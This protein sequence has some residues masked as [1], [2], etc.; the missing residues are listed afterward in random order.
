MLPP[1]GV[2]APEYAVIRLPAVADLTF[3]LLLDTGER[4][5]TDF[6]DSRGLVLDAEKHG[7]LALDILLLYSS[8]LCP[9]LF[10]EFEPGHRGAVDLV[11]AVGKAQGAGARPEVGEREVVRDPGAPVRLYGPVEDVEG[12]VWG[13]DLDHGDLGP[14]LFVP[15]RI[16]HVGRLQGQE[17]RLLYLHPGVR[18]PGLYHTLLRERFPERLPLFDPLAHQLECPFCDADQPHAV[19]DASWPEASLGDG[20]ALA[21]VP[22]DV[23]LRY[24]H[25]VEGDLR[26]PVRGVVV[27]EDGEGPL[28]L[29][30]RRIER[31]QD[32]GLLLVARRVRVRLAHEDG[33][34]AP[35][36][37]CPRD[38]PLLAV[39]DV[40]V[41]VLLYTRHDVSR[42]RGS[43]IRLGHREAG[44]YLTVEQRPQPPLF[45]L[46]C[47][48]A[49]EH[50]HVARVWGVTV[51][52]LGGYRA[53]AH[54]LAQ[55][56]VL[57]VGEACAE[58]RVRQKEV[59]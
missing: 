35:R 1:Y 21:L 37:S 48:V 50:L 46:L 12:D 47:A 24:A 58:V 56:C 9:T 54:D 3:Y 4:G 31:D 36:V 17:A 26:V 27:A 59:P 45:L 8:G 14:G 49:Y 40:L 41:P 51:E 42:V 33:D 44:P 29:Y 34:L 38:P 52:G 22:D 7:V 28:Y 32:H 57:Q 18:D 55:G 5:F 6:T 16:H 39:H 30:A 2:A 20:E 11:G 10:L 53:A 15:Y 13:D 23:L 25:V 43:H 19:V